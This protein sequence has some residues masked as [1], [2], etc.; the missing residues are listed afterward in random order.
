[1]PNGTSPPSAARER[2]A[3]RHITVL[4]RERREARVCECC[5]VAKKKYDRLLEPALTGLATAT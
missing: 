3:S 5:A 2:I 1:M 4:D